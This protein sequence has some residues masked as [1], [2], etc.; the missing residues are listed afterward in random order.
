MTSAYLDI[1][2]SWAGEITVIGVYRPGIGTSQLVRPLADARALAELLEGAERLVTYNGSRFDLPVIHRRLGLRLLDG[3]AHSDLMLHCWRHQ[4]KGG[5]KRVEA[6]LGIQRDTEGIDGLA[7]MRLWEEHCAGSREA[8]ET[9]LRYNREDI[10]N[11]EILEA[12]LLEL[13]ERFPERKKALKRTL[14]RTIHG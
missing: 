9:L 13:D 10:E 2:T 5:L 11:L 14:S 8:L 7:A 3:F 6:T 12:R 1:E 4:L